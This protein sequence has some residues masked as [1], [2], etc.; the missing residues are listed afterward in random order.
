MCVWQHF[1]NVIVHISEPDL[2][3]WFYSVK[4][5]THTTLLSH[6][7]NIHKMGKKKTQIQSNMQ[8]QKV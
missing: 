4:Q 8:K 5:A 7:P 3:V 6:C 1:D 2:L